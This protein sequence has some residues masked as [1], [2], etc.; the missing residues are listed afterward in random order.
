[1]KVIQVEIM[2]KSGSRA[3]IFRS[4]NSVVVNIWHLQENPLVL[5][6]SLVIPASSYMRV[7]AAKLQKQLDEY[8][9][10][11]GDVDDYLSELLRFAD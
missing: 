4:G 2:G 8:C 7:E 6:D 11:T 10:T 3:T 1:M 5:A 9:G